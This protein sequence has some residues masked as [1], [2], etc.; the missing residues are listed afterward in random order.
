MKTYVKQLVAIAAVLTGCS[1]QQPDADRIQTAEFSDGVIPG[2]SCKA[3][4]TIEYGAE[5]DIADLCSS[6]SEMYVTGTVNT[7]KAGDYNLT[8]TATDADGDLSISNST[9][10]VKP[11]PTPEATPE[12]TQESVSETV[13]QP[14]KRPQQTH[15]SSSASQAQSSSGASSS[16]TSSSAESGMTGSSTRPSVTTDSDSGQSSGAPGIKVFS[17]SAGYDSSS[18]QSACMA[19]VNG[20]GGSCFPMG[21]GS[22]VMYSP[23]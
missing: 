19:L 18:A 16:S 13:Q 5:F 14:V 9:V 17:Y 1:V 11:E 6:D 21:D 8:I 7:E 22:G 23:S 3:D 12:P 15:T 10:T 2:V 20:Y 4:Y